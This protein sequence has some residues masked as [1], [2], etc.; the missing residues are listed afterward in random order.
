M[1]EIIEKK[2]NT[3]SP[4][5]LYF[6][7]DNKLIQ[8]TDEINDL[9]DILINETNLD[10]EI[11]NLIIYKKALYNADTIEENELLNILKPIIYITQHL[12]QKRITFQLV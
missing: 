5:A 1:K 8:S 10:N 9:F 7:V 11:K 4:L 6:L 12:Q 2:D 3:Y